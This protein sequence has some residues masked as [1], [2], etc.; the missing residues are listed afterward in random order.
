M[1][2]NRWRFK[3][4]IMHGGL[5]YLDCNAYCPLYMCQISLLHFFMLSASLFI[6]EGDDS[7]LDEHVS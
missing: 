1:S 3:D 5:I 6:L 7:A 4:V 2:D